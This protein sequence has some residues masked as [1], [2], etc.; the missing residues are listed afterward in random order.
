M[1]VWTHVVG[2][3]LFVFVMF[4]LYASPH[5][6]FFGDALTANTTSSIIRIIKDEVDSTIHAS[7][8]PVPRWPILVFLM[9]AYRCLRGSAVY[10][11]FYCVS[12]LVEN[13]V[14]TLDYCGVTILV[15][16]SY[17]PIIYYSFYCYPTYQKMHLAIIIVLNILNLSVMA[18]PKYRAPETRPVRAIA[19]IV[20]A[21]YVVIAMTHLYFL[22]GFS[23]PF[24][25]HC[26]WYLI[27][28]AV[29]YL[30][31]ATFYVSRI[32]ERF[33]PGAFDYVVIDGV[34]CEP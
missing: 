6:Q 33:W 19:Y 4:L 21:S 22:E 14:Q 24:Y 1:N 28:M 27:A 26:F 16:G 20:V 9:C 12:F 3:L 5:E 23:N 13:I 10:H 8:T 34:L 11:G 7:N 30:L 25:K 2:A 18:T 17:I 32:P 15:T 31:G 29:T